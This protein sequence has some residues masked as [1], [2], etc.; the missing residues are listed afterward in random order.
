L[1]G[2][3]HPRTA[4]RDAV[5]D[6]FG[7]GNCSD[8]IVTRRAI[9]SVATYGW[10]DFVYWPHRFASL[11]LDN[12]TL[13]W[14]VEQTGRT[15]DGR[16]SDAMLGHLHRMLADAPLHVLIQHESQLLDTVDFEHAERNRIA[17]RL[18][19]AYTHAED[20]WR[21]L[22]KHCKTIAGATTTAESRVG[23]AELLLEP[24]VRAGHAF[25]PRV[26]DVLAND[27]V[28][29]NDPLA[30]LCGLMINLAG[31]MQLDEAVWPVYNKFHVDWDWYNEEA[32]TALTLIASPRVLEVL[33]ELY[34]ME[35]WYVRNYATGVLERVHTHSTSETILALIDLEDDDFLRGQLGL[36]LA[37]QLDVATADRAKELYLEAPDDRDRSDIRLA[38]IA[39]SYLGDYPLAERE[40][41]EAEIHAEWLD[42]QRR[43]GQWQQTASDPSHTV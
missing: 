24:I 7:N 37:R 9:R 13:P 38:L 1:G 43:L 21:R 11:P 42:F 18:E 22:A 6:Y 19:L 29:R 32:L 33:R 35:P 16:P 20:C 12:D 26:L 28:D 40:E 2:F 23:E 34:V 41:W 3:S 15:D 17:V 4:V 14:V 27:F 10:Q 39:M 5:F 30:W 25:A 8:P 31:K 36:A